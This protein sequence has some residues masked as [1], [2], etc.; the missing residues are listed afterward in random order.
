MARVVQMMMRG[1]GLIVT[2][3]SM[4]VFVGQRSVASTCD[5]VLLSLME[6][7]HREFRKIHPFSF[8]TF[9]FYLFM[10]FC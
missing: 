1:K 8:R 6:R 7:T 9:V 5:S 10:M 4:V 2:L 3:L